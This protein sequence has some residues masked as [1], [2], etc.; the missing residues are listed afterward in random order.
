MS[1]ELETWCNQML[2]WQII[3][4]YKIKIEIIVYYSYFKN[5]N[6]IECNITVKFEPKYE[7]KN[8]VCM[9]I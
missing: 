7:K 3:T 6:E 4:P 2:P 8:C 9:C 5:Q 1:K